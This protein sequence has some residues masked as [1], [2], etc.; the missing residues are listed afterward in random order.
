[1][2]GH[3]RVLMVAVPAAVLLLLVSSPVQSMSVN[4]MGMP[5]ASFTLPSVAESSMH[6]DWHSVDASSDGAMCAGGAPFHFFFRAPNLRGSNFLI[7]F[8]DGSFTNSSATPSSFVTT[9]WSSETCAALRTLTPA[10]CSPKDSGCGVHKLW[11]DTTVDDS[12]ITN[13]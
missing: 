10:D 1:M 12:Y 13:E 9:C 6:D 2:G 7:T 3:L 8:G 4:E 11:G 5:L